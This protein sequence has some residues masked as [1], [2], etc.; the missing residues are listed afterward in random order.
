MPE[1]PPM[2]VDGWSARLSRTPASTDGFTVRTADV[3][4]PPSLA[5]M[6]T[7][8]GSNAPARDVD[9]SKPPEG[10]PRRIR[11]VERNRALR[12]LAGHD[13]GRIQRQAGQPG[14]REEIVA[15]GTEEVVEAFRE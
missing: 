7:R 3:V 1:L 5:E 9:T 12:G 15:R 11:S 10:F 4:T 6:V 14:Q 2:T 13:R 8:T